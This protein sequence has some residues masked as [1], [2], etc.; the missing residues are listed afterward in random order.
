MDTCSLAEEV[1]ELLHV[2]PF[3]HEPQ[4]PAG[5]PHAGPQSFERESHDCGDQTLLKTWARK[6]QSPKMD[7]DRTELSLKLATQSI[8]SGARQNIRLPES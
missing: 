2:D 4:L 6:Q 1:P 8:V 7:G 3:G 5:L